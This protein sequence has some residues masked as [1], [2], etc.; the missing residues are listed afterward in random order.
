M[1]KRW[2]LGLAG[3]NKAIVAKGRPAV[4]PA[5]SPGF[6]TPPAAEGYSTG[7]WCKRNVLILNLISL[8]TLCDF[9]LPSPSVTPTMFSNL[10][11]SKILQSEERSDVKL[12]QEQRLSKW[13][14][15]GGFPPRD[16]KY[17]VSQLFSCPVFMTTSTLFSPLLTF[18]VRNC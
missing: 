2:S 9:F 11:K 14:V 13:L 15:E 7:S 17:H 8:L 4:Q 1:Q 18:S 5:D 12:L 10:H 3:L 16:H 6:E